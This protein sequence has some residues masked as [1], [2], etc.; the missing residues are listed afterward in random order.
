MYWG[1]AALDYIEKWLILPPKAVG[2][3]RFFS[4]EIQPFEI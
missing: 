2:N 3:L 4:V 1:D